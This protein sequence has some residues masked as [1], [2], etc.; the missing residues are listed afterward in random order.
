MNST[1][2]SF[3]NHG[4]P[5]IICTA[6]TAW[7]TFVF[8]LTNYIAHCVTLKTY[9]GEDL[10]DTAVAVFLAL[11]FP[12]SGIIRALDAL[13]RHSRF[14]KGHELQ[15]A[16]RAGALVTIVRNKYW[17]AE[18]DDIISDLAPQIQNDSSKSNKD[19][20]ELEK[21]KKSSNLEGDLEKGKNP[22]KAMPDQSS[23]LSS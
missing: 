9:P 10:V 13:Q 22:A 3:F 23:S 17:G 12:A 20:G 11:C 8:F 21:S 5:N 15:R 7:S 16:A 4:D 18:I 14:T 6:A 1:S 2:S 19:Q